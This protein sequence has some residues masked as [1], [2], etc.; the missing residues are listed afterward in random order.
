[1]ETDNEG[2][3][4]LA[5]INKTNQPHSR[6]ERQKENARRVRVLGSERAKK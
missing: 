5:E 6:A 4:A 3:D 1:M 2:D